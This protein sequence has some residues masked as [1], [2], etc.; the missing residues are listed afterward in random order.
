[1]RIESCPRILGYIGINVRPIDEP[2]GI[3]GDE[4]AD[5]IGAGAKGFVTYLM[6]EISR[7][8]GFD[9]DIIKEI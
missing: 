7:A 1:M 2:G 3:A 4:G 6:G 9:D 5:F 8:I